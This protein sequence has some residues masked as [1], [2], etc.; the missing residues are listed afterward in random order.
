[1]PDYLGLRS[2]D[3]LEGHNDL[4]GGRIDQLLHTLNLSVGTWRQVRPL[5]VEAPAGTIYEAGQGHAPL[6]R[7][8]GSKW[9][10]MAEAIRM[11]PAAP[12]LCFK[13]LAARHPD[14]LRKPKSALET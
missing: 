10:L 14:I 4:T 6:F 7:Y 13:S 8:P 9:R 1:M 3:T 2:G 11:F 5:D 12:S